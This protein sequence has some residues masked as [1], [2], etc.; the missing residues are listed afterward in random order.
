MMSCF[1]SRTRRNTGC[2]LVTGV[3]TCAVPIF[4]PAKG[5]AR[6]QRCGEEARQ[7]DD[8]LVGIAARVLDIEEA[9]AAR[10]AGLVD[11]HHG[12]FHEELGRAS[13]RVRVCQSVVISVADVS[14]RKPPKLALTK[15]R[16]T[17]HNTHH[18]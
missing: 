13:C 17:T 14:V 1:V 7:G 9:F 6:G 4:F 5:N 15:H 18:K 3:Q 16:R 11:Y 2:A 12:L 8:A 10:S